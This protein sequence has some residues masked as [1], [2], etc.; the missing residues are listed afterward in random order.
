MKKAVLVGLCVIV[1]AGLLVLWILVGGR[2]ADGLPPRTDSTAQVDR[3]PAAPDPAPAE[4]TATSPVATPSVARSAVGPDERIPMCRVSCVVLERDSLAAVA[5]A[6]IALI[7]SVPNGMQELVELGVTNELGR[8]D[9]GVPGRPSQVHQRLVA[10][11]EGYAHSLAELD[12]GS[13]L[14]HDPDFEARFLLMHAGSISGAV[15]DEGGSPVAGARVGGFLV[16]KSQVALP[17]GSL[18]EGKRFAAMAESDVEGRFELP[19]LPVGASLALPVDATGFPRHRTEPIAVGSQD[20]VVVLK[21]G[22]ATLSG[23]VR[24]HRGVPMGNLRVFLALPETTTQEDLPGVALPRVVDSATSDNTGRYQFPG[25]TAGT[26]RPLVGGAWI[27][28]GED[29]SGG[30][31]TLEV[32]DHREHDLQLPAP[33]T[34]EGR[35][36]DIATGD[37][38]PGVELL[39]PH[40]SQFASDGSQAPWPRTA[41]T[42]HDGRFRIEAYPDAGRNVRLSYNLPGGWV[43]VENRWPGTLMVGD[44]ESEGTAHA[45][46]SLMRSAM[47]AGVVLAPDGTSPA[48]GARIQVTL[49]PY[50][51]R[52][53]ATTDAQGRFLLNVPP[54]AEVRVNASWREAIASASAKAGAA[55]STTEMTIRLALPASIGGRVTAEGKSVEGLRVELFVQE[56]PRRFGSIS[57]TTRPDGHYHFG[58]VEPGEI[59]VKAHLPPSMLYAAPAPRVLQIAA[60]ETLDNVDFALEMGRLFEGVVTDE[61]GGAIEGARVDVPIGIPGHGARYGDHHAVTDADGY[62]AIGGFAAGD[63]IH[64]I[65]VNKEGYFSK[66]HS[67]EG[68]RV[69]GPYN[70]VLVKKSEVWMAVYAGSPSA[71]VSR[72]RYR[73]QGHMPPG[74]MWGGVQQRPWLETNDPSGRQRLDIP[75]GEGRYRVEVMELGVDG[76]PTGRAGIGDFSLFPNLP[77]ETVEVD[78]GVGRSLSGR[79]RTPAG[80]GLEGVTIGLSVPKTF[81]S[82]ENALEFFG[83]RA[84]TD[85]NGEFA[86][87]HV[88]PGEYWIS[89]FREQSVGF[90]DL[91]VPATGPVASVEFVVGD[92]GSLRV[93]L[94]AASSMTAGLPAALDY[95]LEPTGAAHASRE[96]T[97]KVEVNASGSGTIPE[98]PFGV[99]RGFLTL[100]GGETLEGRDVARL[101]PLHPESSLSF[102]S[103]GSAI[104]LTGRIRVNDR[105]WGGDPPLN[106]RWHWND[107][108]LI[109]HLGEGRYRTTIHRAEYPTSTLSLRPIPYSMEITQFTV[110]PGV[111]EF[112]QDFD[113]TLGDVSVVVLFPEGEAPQPGRVQAQVS[114]AEGLWATYNPERQA[115]LVS[116]LPPGK[117]R[118]SYRSSDELWLGSKQDV[119]VRADGRDVVEIEAVPSSELWEVGRWDSSRMGE[120]PVVLEFDASRWSDG[121]TMFRLKVLHEEGDGHI[122]VTRVAVLV[123]GREIAVSSGSVLAGKSRP[124]ALIAFDYHG[125]RLEPGG[126]WKV[127]FRIERRGEGTS[128]GQI[129]AEP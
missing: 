119:E 43:E 108:G 50:R 32:G 62:Y 76:S 80:G 101:S 54:E 92:S 25:L 31:V 95:R 58:G 12:T 6:R 37:G 107:N 64:S 19:G 33:A 7:R 36:V 106:M 81:A 42:E 30:L 49:M 21:R 16:E 1:G 18:F 87:H 57:E 28:P 11:K 98:V 73:V 51:S 2:T 99:Y 128:R 24:D 85:A 60:G 5:G 45:E 79:V 83:F 86:L 34:I 63:P 84:Q 77:T 113:L 110:P 78:V 118:F 56:G 71:P 116:S 46:L 94:A 10:L 88:P 75:G 4:R 65:Q 100:P 40:L 125:D 61:A 15:M 38:V 96:L 127:T 111:T 3:R 103:T 13:S 102:Q 67:L 124:V 74:T 27:P 121:K 70:F 35:A 9:V 41:T 120:E 20:V 126:L 89:A 91:I 68:E 117:Y 55:G 90:Q 29:P 59:T 8:L 22:D 109:E 122:E 105:P 39:S 104:V 82:R 97:G 44:V 123:N 115:A 52:P 114:H 17:T 14:A 48:A 93:Y 72:Y 47:I 23:I 129:V 53:Q 66:V 26:Y 112:E 69:A